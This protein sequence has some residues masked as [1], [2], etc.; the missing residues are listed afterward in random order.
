MPQQRGRLLSRA[1]L[2]LFKREAAIAVGVECAQAARDHGQG[3]DFGGA[4]LAVMVAI[5]AR[6][7]QLFG[8]GRRSRA[9]GCRAA[10]GWL[11]QRLSTG[12][13]AEH[14]AGKQDKATRFECAA[15]AGGLAFMGENSDSVKNLC[16]PLHIG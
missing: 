15:G 16:I 2:E 5:G 9:A 14:Q 11:G 13:A 4:E 1:P 7:S 6:K 12:R 10:R 3:L 8:A